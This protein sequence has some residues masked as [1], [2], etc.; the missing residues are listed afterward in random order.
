M[1]KVA[2]H[3]DHVDEKEGG[4][5]LPP[6]PGTPIMLVELRLRCY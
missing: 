5:Q 2:D 4:H 6:E 3:P 1:I